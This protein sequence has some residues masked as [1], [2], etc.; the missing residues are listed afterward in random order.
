LS[1]SPLSCGGR[2]GWWE[3]NTSKINEK[4]ESYFTKSKEVKQNE[5]K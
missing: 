2:L 1:P 3:I 5:G 4:K